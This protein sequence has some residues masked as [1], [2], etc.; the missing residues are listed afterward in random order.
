M[1][2]LFL[3]S[4]ESY[5]PYLEVDNVRVG[6]EGVVGGSGLEGTLPPSE[7]PRDSQTLTC[8]SS[9]QSSSSLGITLTFLSDFHEQE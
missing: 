9:P 8:R 1:S 7:L 5:L 2:S 3:T 4:V 6:M